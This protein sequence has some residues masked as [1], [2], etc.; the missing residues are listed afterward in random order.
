LYH[1]EQNHLAQTFPKLSAHPY[2]TQ[3]NTS[4]QFKTAIEFVDRFI[5]HISNNLS[6]FNEQYKDLRKREQETIVDEYAIFDE[7]EYI[8]VCSDKQLKLLKKMRELK[9]TLS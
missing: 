1:I 3:R 6:K 2:L 8:G 9:K 7:D 5:A 4:I